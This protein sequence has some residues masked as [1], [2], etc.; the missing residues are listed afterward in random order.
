[1][2]CGCNKKKL[3][4]KSVVKKPA[5]QRTTRIVVNNGRVKRN[6]KRLIR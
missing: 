5:L 4:H 2:G 6:E 3:A 1:M